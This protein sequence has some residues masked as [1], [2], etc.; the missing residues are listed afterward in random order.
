MC[1]R[2]SLSKGLMLTGWSYKGFCGSHMRWFSS[3]LILLLSGLPHIYGHA[4]GGNVGGGSE[5]HDQQREWSGILKYMTSNML[6]EKRSF[7]GQ[8]PTLRY[9]FSHCYTPG[10]LLYLARCTDSAH[11]CRTACS[12]RTVASMFCVQE[13]GS[14]SI[15]FLVL[16]DCSLL[17]C[18]H[19]GDL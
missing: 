13:W 1:V 7:W 19:P 17:H 11:V 9:L 3:P 2:T 16:D 18:P 14:E 8:G 5:L 6:G 15:Q 4:R 10:D 12:N